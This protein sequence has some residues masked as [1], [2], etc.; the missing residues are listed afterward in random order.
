MKIDYLT[1]Y[2]VW[3]SSQWPKQHMGMYTAGY[4]LAQSLEAQEIPLNY[5]GPLSRYKTPI[6]R[7]KWL[8]YRKFYQ[9]DYYSWAEAI[10]FKN[11]ARQIEKKLLGS[12][13]NLVLCPE[14]AIPLADLKCSKPLVLWTD[15]PLAS[16]VNF[17]EYL[18]NLCEETKRNIYQLE[19]AALE[20]CD[21]LFF[22]SD[23]AAQEAIQIY[24]LSPEKVQIIPWGANLQTSRHQADIQAS[25]KQRSPNHC[26][27]VFIGVEWFRKG[28][29]FAVE[30][31]RYLNEA[32]LKTT[33]NI[34]GCHPP[35]KN[36]PDFINVIGYV[37]KS[38][39]S[40]REKFDHLLSTAHFL[41]LRTLADCSPHVL[42]E[43]N[44]YGV[45]CVAS[46]V[47]GISTIIQSGKN[48]EVF[49]LETEALTYAEYILKR[50]QNY[51]EYEA[52]ALSSFQEYEERLN[53]KVSVQTFRQYT[54]GVCSES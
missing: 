29:D 37:D 16:L 5:I 6:T 31:A 44:S 50:V 11:Y 27:L 34:I 54:V 45:P 3:N 35:L 52:L 10:V 14:N 46:E 48:G 4:Y 26:Q 19:K 33:L 9:K 20:K 30:I 32:G 36:I 8:F 7:W 23:W 51:L 17:Y 38:T 28:G 1:T 22:T 24:H 40:G 12:S 53:W 13:G 42:M 49:S 25:L 39:P 47:G 18:Q 15:A 41:I 2:D 21:R 43:A